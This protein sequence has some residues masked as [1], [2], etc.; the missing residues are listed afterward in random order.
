MLSE[1]SYIKRVDVKTYREQ[2]RGGQGVTGS[3]LKEED[4]VRL[5][6]TCSTHDYLL[7]FT[8]RGR[9]FWLKANDVPVAERQGR[10]KALANVLDMRDEKIAYLMAL[11]DFEK[12]YL[13]FATKLGIVKKLP[14]KD[15][16]K[17]RNAGVRVIN[18]PAD[19]SDVVID[20]RRV[21]DGQEVM[22]CTSKGQAIRFNADEVGID[23][24]A[25]AT[26]LRA[27]KLERATKLF[28]WKA[29]QRT[30]KPRC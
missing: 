29:C 25:Q 17:P 12:D 6:V 11:K 28:L 2:K 7:F 4:F 24:T 9:V 3:D 5:M 14:L 23:G 8:T 20:V 16:S 21:E 15:V 10:G 1:T 30:A 13:M 27:Q 19:N 26:G 22:L 18:L